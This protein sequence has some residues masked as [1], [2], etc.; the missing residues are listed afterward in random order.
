M[1]VRAQ[2]WGK[3]R[4]DE[5]HNIKIYLYAFGKMRFVSTDYY[6]CKKDWD[7]DKRM[8]L[9]THPNADN[10]NIEL[11]S[12]I[13]ELEKKA[14]LE[15]EIKVSHI[16]KSA[17]KPVTFYEF[18]EYYYE[19]TKGK[20]NLSKTGRPIALSSG[21]AMRTH[22]HRLM[23]FCKKVEFDFDDV[24]VKL[25]KRYVNYL[26]NEYILRTKYKK[27]IRFG[28]SENSISKSVEIFVRIMKL[29]WDEKLHDNRDALKFTYSRVTTEQIALT[30]KEIDKIMKAELP[31][32]LEVERDRFYISYNF[33]LRFNDSIHIEKTDIVQENG[34]HFL[35]TVHEKTHK[36][37]I[38]PV[39]KKT[40]QILKKHDYKLPKTT[41]QESNWKLKEIGKIAGV[42]S[43]VT[44]TE[45]RKGIIIKNVFKKYELITTH[46]TRRSMATN[47]YLNGFELKQIQLM[48]GWTNTRTLELYLKIDSMD[49]A[50]KAS[51]HPFFTK[52]R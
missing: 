3:A 25:Y 40:L 8:V 35:H 13:L 16:I 10:I 48:G 11:K 52:R 30:E 38:I 21:R 42:D 9:K 24:N 46:T 23:G 51:K 18:L 20:N 7:P 44:I 22:L 43:D 27:E 36:K 32:H 15:P 45:I 19:S 6:V 12:K 41:N 37:V 47:L 2:L 1:R 34:N 29:S 28:L 50:I 26:H 39:F 14:L 31:K 49:N 4:N 33:L 5:R 17:D